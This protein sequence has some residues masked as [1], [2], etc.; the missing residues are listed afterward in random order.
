MLEFLLRFFPVPSSLGCCCTPNLVF[1]QELNKRLMV[2]VPAFL[3]RLCNLMCPLLAGQP[4]TATSFS[5]H[6]TASG[7]SLHMKS[8]LSGLPFYWDFH[9]CPAPVEMVS[10]AAENLGC[11]SAKIKYCLLM[12]GGFWVVL[13]CTGGC[14]MPGSACCPSRGSVSL[15]LPIED[16]APC[17][18]PPSEAG[19]AQRV[20]LPGQQGDAHF[21]MMP[22]QC[23]A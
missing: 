10:K 4:D 6:R 3:H 16:L 18:V 22:H 17:S 20:L 9:C 13:G 15:F 1:R 23:P 14:R 12:L 8:E 5:C 19:M 21:G 7:L 2:P 11:G